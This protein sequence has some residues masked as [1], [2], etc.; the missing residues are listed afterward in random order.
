[1]TT[2]RGSTNA[3]GRGRSRSSS[4]DSGPARRRQGTGRA[5]GAGGA[6]GAGEAAGDGGAAAPV[7]I[8]ALDPAAQIEAVVAAALAAHVARSGSEAQHEEPEKE[9]ALKIDTRNLK[10]EPFDGS[11]LEGNFDSKTRDFVEELSDQIEDAQTLAGQEWSDAAKRAIL[12][13]FL[14]GTALKWYRDWRSVNPA[15]SYADSCDALIH[16]YRPVLLST[17][18]TNRIRKEKKR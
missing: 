8:A 2:T 12:K 6:V 13:M 7:G 5:A 9:P 4:A 11:V 16:E 3:A 14:T 15:A 17:D 18:V 10:V 1:M